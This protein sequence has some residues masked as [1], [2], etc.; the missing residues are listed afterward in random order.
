MGYKHLWLFKSHASKC[1]LLLVTL[2][3]AYSASIFADV[4]LDHR[5]SITSIPGWVVP[6]EPGKQA[7]SDADAFGGQR[8]L[9]LDRQ[10]YNNGNTVAYHRH[11][12]SKVVGQAGLS[13]TSNLSISFDPSYQRLE[14][15]TATVKRKGR[16]SDRLAQARIEIARTENQ[17]QES[18]LHGQVTALIVLPDIRV[19]DQLETRYTIYGRNPVFESRHHSSWRVRWGVPIERSVL[20]VT[21]P[22]DMPLNRTQID[23]AELVESVSSGL[24]TLH[25]QW[26]N[27]E[28][29]EVEEDVPGWIPNPD[30]LQITAYRN[31]EEVA[32]WGARLFKGHSANGHAY[33]ELSQ[34]VQQVADEQGLQAAMA[35]AIDHVQT[36]IR[37]YGVEVGVNSHRPHSPDEVLRNGYG[38]CKDKTLL[39]VSLLN[40]LGVEAWPIL[41]SSRIRKG[42][43]D[44]L[45][46][47]GV[48]N[49]VVVLVEH[50]GKQYWVDATDNSQSG[51]LGYRGQPEYGAGLVL[52]KSNEAIIKRTAPTPELATTAMHD[53]FYLSSMGGPVD[54]LTTTTYRERGANWFRRELDESGKRQ[55]QKN[56]REYYQEI[57]GELRSLGTL[58]ITRDDR[59]NTITV[60]ESYRLKEL[61]EID[62]R[63]R[64]VEFDTYAINIRTKLN[65]FSKFKKNRKAPLRV[66]GPIRATHKLQFFPNMASSER[67]LEELSFDIAGFKYR[68]SEYVLG[69]SLVFDSELLISTD[70]VEASQLKAYKKFRERV[71]RNAQSGR[72][73]PLADSKEIEL[74]AK[75]ASVLQALEGLE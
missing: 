60:K 42:I 51:F 37:Y 22:D 15:H 16:D 75:T 29:S 19:G 6:T 65:D 54:L 50:E 14:L 3:A 63:S 73:Y 18:L 62:K 34:S 26:D 17:N 69:D 2:L 31:W 5:Y 68:D 38:D 12:I 47:P 35:M 52:G 49:H 32:A 70:N 11:D 28:P 4:S 36:S 27:L 33:S 74:G 21:V 13:D 9:L 59:L 58:E 46:S 61:W 48:F 39:L 53:Q 71:M 20:R 66:F 55:L 24:R 41:V 25:W 30:R 67:P 72:Y 40:D 8:Y 56:Y 43:V 1:S 7:A 44:H 64:R 57:Y 45:P 23:D 10:H